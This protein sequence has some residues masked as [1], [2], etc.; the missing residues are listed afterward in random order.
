MQTN[1]LPT[2]VL[3]VFCC[4]MDGNLNLKNLKSLSE[5]RKKKS[6]DNGFT[7]I[8]FLCLTSKAGIFSIRE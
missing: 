1:S 6:I 3:F 5:N 4:F 8:F 7:L 2:F